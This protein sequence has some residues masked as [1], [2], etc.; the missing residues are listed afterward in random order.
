MVSPGEAAGVEVLGGVGAVIAE[1]GF[2]PLPPPPVRPR[3]A[4][5]PSGLGSLLPS[6]TCLVNGPLD[7]NSLVAIL[8]GMHNLMQVQ[9]QALHDLQTKVGFEPAGMPAASS[10]GAAAPT[11]SGYQRTSSHSSY[12]S[13]DIARRMISNE[14][15]V[16]VG[17]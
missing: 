10:Q 16:A 5:P 2:P 15:M 13:Y 17:V 7:V 12:F 14:M 4:L 9:G 6:A 3:G 8:A 11:G 1:G